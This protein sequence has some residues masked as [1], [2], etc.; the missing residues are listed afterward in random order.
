M[1]IYGLHP[2]KLSR[3]LIECK[4]RA[5]QV[6]GGGGNSNGG[7]WRKFKWREVEE[8]Q[9]EGDGGNSSGG[10]WRKFTWRE[11]EEVQA[12]ENFVE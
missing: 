1:H 10:R 5:A 4:K 7:R 11:M 8:I 12:E 2:N 6:E 9:V 3:G